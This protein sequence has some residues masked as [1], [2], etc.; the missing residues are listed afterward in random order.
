MRKILSLFLI[1]ILITGLTAC[2]KGEEKTEN[3]PSQSVGASS[4][5]GDVTALFAPARAIATTGGVSEKRTLANTYKCLTEKKELNVLYIGGSLTVGTGSTN[6]ECWRAYTTKWFKEAYPNAKINEINSAIGGTGSIFGLARTKRDIIAYKPDLV[7]IEFA[8]NDTYMGLTGA[9][10]G[11]YMEGMVRQINEALP[12]CDIIFV[13]TTDQSRVG[14]NY[15]MRDAHIQIADFYGVPYIDVGAALVEPVKAD[16]WSEYATDVVH[17]NAKGYRIY[18]DEVIKNLKTF[19]ADAKGKAGGTHKLPESFASSNPAAT[20]TLMEAEAVVAVNPEDW[21]LIPKRA[22][23]D[24]SKSSAFAKADEAKL[25]FEFDGTVLCAVG[26]KNDKGEAIFTVDGV[27][28]KELKK[29][30]TKEGEIM[31]IDNLK[32]GHHKV[33]IKVTSKSLQIDGFMVG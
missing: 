21:R 32:P 6:T 8:M 29:T 16:G 3:N 12:S 23:H 7:F 25:S 9:Q 2:S 4:S 11:T 10:A 30:Y 1:F 13:L 5:A 15:I 18:A 26:K 22:V 27:V 33:E 24:S 14:Q 28:A 17:L 19:L 31:V 20:L